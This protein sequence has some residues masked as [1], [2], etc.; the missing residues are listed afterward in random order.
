MTRILAPSDMSTVLRLLG[1]AGLPTSDL[2]TAHR[3]EF[4]ALGAPDAPAG[5]IGLER[6]GHVALLRSLAVAEGRRGEGLGSTL[7]AGVEAAAAQGGITHLYLLTTTAEAF[8]AA[9]GYQAVARHQAPDAIQATREFSSLCPDTAVVMVKAMDPAAE[10][11]GTDALR[12]RIRDLDRTLV[13][14]AAE[15]VAVARQVGEAKRRADQPIVDYAQERVVL[16]RA[17]DVADAVGLDRHVA[18][19]ILVTL[20][21][22][23][24][25]AQDQDNWRSAAVGHGKTAVVVGGAGR[26]GRWF[27]RFL[28]DQGYVAGALDLRSTGDEQAWAEA[29]LPTADLVVCSTPPAAT[30]A[31]YERWLASPPSGVIVDI[32]SIK[33]PLIDAIRRLQHAGA[34]VASVHPMFGPSVVLLRDCD[35]VICDTGDAKATTTVEQLFKSTTARLLRLPLDEHDRLMADV[36]TLAH[37]TVIAFALALPDSSVPVRSTTL[38][39]LQGL[40]AN[41]VRESPDVYYEIQALN[42]N[43]AGAL[44]RLARAIDRVRDA[45]GSRDAGAFSAL[46]REGEQKTPIE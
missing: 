5:V 40:S 44:D 43:S 29:T 39:A 30:A 12:A 31:L 21:R 27:T 13:E 3:V 17:R 22:A 1:A 18:E 10:G 2:L 42:P 28:A 20:I 36:L 34:A 25:G 14:L 4:F 8:F 33:T 26:M 16:E 38:G 24:V 9:R 15:R 6:V 7:V 11:T 32:A 35:V 37:A 45:I 46:M 19:A 41:L 23:A